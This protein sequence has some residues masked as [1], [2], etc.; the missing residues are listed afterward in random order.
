MVRV[1]VKSGDGLKMIRFPG[2]S[3][4]DESFQRSVNRGPRYPGN[5]FFDLFKHL[6]HSRVIVAIEQRVEDNAAVNRH[7][8]SPLA[9]QRLKAFEFV[10][11]VYR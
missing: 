7:R 10:L 3:E 2:D 9:T 4:V 11:F 1:A 5:S 6:I 8:Q